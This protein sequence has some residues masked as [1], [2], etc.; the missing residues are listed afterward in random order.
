MTNP[1]ASPDLSEAHPIAAALRRKGFVPLPRLWVKA[2]DMPAIFGITERYRDEVVQTRQ[3]VKERLGLPP[4]VPLNTAL[5]LQR[6]ER[7]KTA[8][9]EPAAAPP[10][11]DPL[12]DREAAWAAFEQNRHAS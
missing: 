12:T 2:A 9:M 4:D 5:R 7:T 3:D 8:H 6:L 11:G 1:I 10:A